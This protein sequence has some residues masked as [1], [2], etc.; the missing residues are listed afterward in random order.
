MSFIPAAM[1][2]GNPGALVD[3]V[4]NKLGLWYVSLSDA[5][6]TQ[7]IENNAKA[8]EQYHSGNS[9]AINKIVGH[10]MKRHRGADAAEVCQRIIQLI[11]GS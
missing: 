1:W 3:F 11:E 5:E 2:R 7:A 4:I 10:V 9:R 6:L 8:V